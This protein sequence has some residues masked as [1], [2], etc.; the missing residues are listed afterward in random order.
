MIIGQRSVAS[1]RTP[2]IWDSPVCSFCR[3]TPI[4]LSA[5]NSSA[6]WSNISSIS[7]GR[8]GS[9]QTFSSC[10]PGAPPSG[11]FSG[12]LPARQGRPAGCVFRGALEARAQILGQLGDDLLLDA[13]RCSHRLAG[14]VVGRAAQA[15]RHDQEVDARPLSLQHLDDAAQLVGN[16]CDQNDTNAERL[17]PLGEPR[18]VRVRRVAGHE[19]VADGEDRSSHVPEYAEQRADL[20]RDVLDLISAGVAPK[21]AVGHADGRKQQTCPS[22]PLGRLR[23]P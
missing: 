12:R 2:A 11:F 1:T 20:G 14:D 13:E 9:T 23:S 15:A 4:G 7:R 5:R 3:H 18:R 6:W 19:L 16:R 22:G 17:Q 21:G 8:P 10:R